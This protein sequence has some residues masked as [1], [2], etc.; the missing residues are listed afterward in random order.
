MR[1]RPPS[2]ER[3]RT[4]VSSPIGQRTCI[5]CRRIED[6]TA[7]VRVVLSHPADAAVPQ[8]VADPTRSAPGRGAWLHPRRECLERAERTRSFAR[9]FRRAVDPA[10]LLASW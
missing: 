10:P 8:V 9:A 7:L 1:A 6:R 2:T 3:G 5:G 4:A